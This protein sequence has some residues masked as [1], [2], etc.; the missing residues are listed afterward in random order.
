ME[1]EEGLCLHTN[2]MTEPDVSLKGE[3]AVW[4]EIRRGD[5]TEKGGRKTQVKY[6]NKDAHI[7]LSIHDNKRTM[8]VDG[9]NTFFFFLL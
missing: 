9:F 2:S 4:V 5:A 8:F 6:C 7:A 3:R 1:G